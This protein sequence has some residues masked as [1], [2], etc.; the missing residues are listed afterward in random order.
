M[1]HGVPKM[2]T[3]KKKM[4]IWPIAI[5]ISFLLFG[6]LVF[7][8]MYFMLN[9]KIDL[10]HE[11]YYAQEVAFQDHIDKRNQTHNEGK[12]P[13]FDIDRELRLMTIGFAYDPKVDQEPQGT[14][15]FF[16]PS[17][18]ELD[19]ELEVAVDRSGRMLIP[20]SMLQ[21]GYWRVRIDWKEGETAYFHEE[22]I[23]V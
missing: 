7:G 11:D 2:K 1:P 21:H 12:I 8:S 4:E 18:K 10:V 3:T 14:I 23:Q 17:N 22:A 15:H 13:A 16:R 6:G 20:L 9:S 19:Q 5:I